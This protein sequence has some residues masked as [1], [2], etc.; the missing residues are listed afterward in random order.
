VRRPLAECVPNFS[1]GR[2][3][4]KVGAIVAA[5]ESTDGVLLLDS[6]SDADHNRCV[7]TFVGPPQV[8]LEGALR[9]AAKAFELIDL[10]RHEGVHPRI[11]AMDVLPFVPLEDLTLQDC[12]RL[13]WQAGEEIWRRLRVPVYLYEAAAL[14]PERV[15]LA[16]IRRG[17]FEGLRQ[18]APRNP[19]RRPDIG[20]PE[21]HPTA[22]A[23]AVGARK[24]LIAFNVNLETTDVEVAKRIA[25]AVRSSSG[26]LPY[27]KAMGVPLR[28]R[29]QVQ[30]SMNLTVFEQTPLQVA[31]EAVR[32]EAARHG[33]SV[34][35]SEI[36]G[37]ALP[38]TR[39]S[40][41]AN[42]IRHP[43]HHRNPGVRI[44]HT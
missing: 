25:R 19:D 20:G 39:N 32:R 42:V 11:G 2:D 27:L 33:V 1:E 41:R 35:G 17:Q 43:P 8:V 7:V 29:N 14:R 6:A 40:F 44:L 23:A 24:F 12:A 13:A 31:F 34:A 16:E 22:G 36:V 37:L 4:A 18:E 38:F 3:L 5:I 10:N 28:S 15:N 9:G 26:G 21:L 30:V